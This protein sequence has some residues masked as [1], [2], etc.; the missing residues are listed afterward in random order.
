MPALEIHAEWA[1]ALA[2]KLV[3]DAAILP[4]DLDDEQRLTLAWALKDRAIAAWYGNPSDVVIASEALTIL[5]VKETKSAASREELEI[6]AVGEWLLGIS[7]LVRGSMSDALDNL[8]AATRQFEAI[9]LKGHAVHAQVSKIM[10]LAVLGRHAEA[11]ASGLSNQRELVRLGDLHSAAKVSLNLGNM[12]CQCND[13]ATALRHFG[14]AEALF[15]GAGDHEHSIA[16][17]IGAAEA[18]SSTGDFSKALELYERSMRRATQYQLPVA[19]GVATE[20]IA[21]VSLACGRYA[22]ALN[23]LESCRRQYETLDMAQNLAMAEKQLG[24]AYLELRLAPEALALFDRMLVR[25]KALEMP[26]EQAWAH[27]QRGRALAIMNRPD[28][29]IAKALSSAADLFLHQGVPAGEATVLLARAEMGL[30]HRQYALASELARE[31][32][33]RFAAADL[34]AGRAHASA[35]L[36]HA[37]LLNG[38][39]L[40]AATVFSTTLAEAR[41]LQLLSIQV[42]CLVGLGSV[43]QRNGETDAARLSFESAIE[44]FEEQRRVLPDDDL[45]SAFLVDQMR[46][47]EELLRFALARHRAKRSPENAN[48]VLIQLERFKAR[49]IGERLG[50]NRQVMIGNAANNGAE[51]A[52]RVRLNWLYRRMRRLI[53]EGEETQTVSR[54]SR[55]I[56]RELLEQARRRRLT[57]IVDISNPPS[58]P[59]FAYADE[60]VSSF[61]P[62][63]VLIEYGL[64]D[65]ELFAC[66][67]AK[68]GVT[69]IDDVASWMQVKQAISAARFQIETLRYGA[70][71]VGRHRELLGQRVQAAMK[72][73]HDLVWVPVAAALAGRRSI[74][75]VPHEELGSVQFAALFDGERYLSERYEFASVPSAQLALRGLSRIPVVPNRVLVLGET[76]R[77]QNAAEEARLVASLFPAA[78]VLVGE[79]ANADALRT[80]VASADVL[81][82][83]CHGQ[84]RSDNPMFSALHFVDAPFTVGDAEALDLKQGIVV[85]SACE[86]GVAQYSRGDEMMGLVRGFMVAG[87]ARVVASLWPVDD[88]ITMQ[89][90]AVFYR[91]LVGGNTPSAALRTE[92]LDVMRAHPH[93]FHWA[94]FT[95]YGGW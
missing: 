90:M 50:E 91:S 94:A 49:I 12:Y 42:R 95:L 63:E 71:S 54:E 72:R 64:L 41:E 74:L 14:E 76:T 25:C 2:E 16:C 27:V 84:F 51:E 68:S 88:A 22:D 75:I 21:L 45:R 58:N 43:A 47:Y 32:S 1:K 85:L 61:G 8:D 19:V 38:E 57:G 39:S 83:A 34:S 35:L 78:Q 15:T 18:H 77:L 82:L 89:F 40:E 92:Q 5:R 93:P 13:Y 53:D 69:V 46:P 20:A 59:S 10:A 26:V 11:I 28:D 66:V 80:H 52:L 73:I 79:N 7:A 86:T 55:R 65:D 44:L 4:T 87:A 33:E 62:S 9:D 3:S 70:G 37:L 24:D 56:E 36:A 17:E 6:R 29:Q 31:A 30:L 81:H 60:L 67:V 48:D 23:G